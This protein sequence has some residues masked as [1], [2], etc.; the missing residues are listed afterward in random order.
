[1]DGRGKVVL[2][3]GSR[4]SRIRARRVEVAAGSRRRRRRKVAR[5][6]W[7][8]ERGAEMTTSVGSESCGVGEDG[9]TGGG[10]DVGFGRE[11]AARVWEKG[12]DY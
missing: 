11:A 2:E 6:E 8:R 1:M 4:R 7:R 12:S 3:V 5:G 9:N 10:C